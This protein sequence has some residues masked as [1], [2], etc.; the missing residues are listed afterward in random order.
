MRENRPK[1]GELTKSQKE[2]D[3]CRSYAGVYLRRGKIQKRPCFICGN[4]KSEMHHD[5]YYKPL[6][7]T[8]VCKKHHFELE[9]K[10]RVAS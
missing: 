6:N 9:K 4:P 5:D 3:R 7:V 1:Y 8:W 2:K 10:K